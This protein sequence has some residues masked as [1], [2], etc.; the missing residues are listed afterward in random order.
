MIMTN[1]AIPYGLWLTP[2]P[3]EITCAR[4]AAGPNRAARAIGG[5]RAAI[6][7]DGDLAQPVI[8][9]LEMNF[10]PDTLTLFSALVS[11]VQARCT[12]PEEGV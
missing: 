5:T 1:S 3:P 2:G 4:E 9:S 8:R 10:R 7:F 11:P 12:L 6:A